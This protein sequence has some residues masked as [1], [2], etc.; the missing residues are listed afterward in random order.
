MFLRIAYF[1]TASIFFSDYKQ[2]FTALLLKNLNNSIVCG[3]AI[4]YLLWHNLQA[5]SY[6]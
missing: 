3:E 4:I 2:N 5:C 6:F 1:L